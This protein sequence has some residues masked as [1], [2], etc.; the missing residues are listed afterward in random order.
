MSKIN[1]TLDK[2]ISINIQFAH[3]RDIELFVESLFSFPQFSHPETP[4]CV[5]V[6]MR[7]ICVIWR[8]KDTRG[9]NACEYIY[10]I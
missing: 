1:S 2:A 8:E 4:S 9:G 7:I 5:C 3:E 10:N 6:Y